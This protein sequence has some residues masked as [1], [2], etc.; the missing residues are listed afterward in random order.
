MDKANGGGMFFSSSGDLCASITNFDVSP[1][2]MTPMENI[3]F[4]NWFIN[5]S[6]LYCST[7]HS[8]LFSVPVLNVF[9]IVRFPNDGCNTT[10]STYGV[11]Y[12]ST[13]CA[14]HGG[15]ARGTCASGFGVCCSCKKHYKLFQ[16][17]C[18]SSSLLWF[19]SRLPAE[20]VSPSTTPTYKAAMVTPH[21]ASTPSVKP[22]RIY[23]SLGLDLQ[24]LTLL[25]QQ[26]R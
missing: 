9:R 3:V 19:Q 20:K 1:F 18:Y 15:T 6:V 23:V 2:L 8:F 26:Q 11:C 16:I 10:V 14:S 5:T 7:H 21:P 4:K 24:H 22:V 13:E 25:N 17:C 12:T